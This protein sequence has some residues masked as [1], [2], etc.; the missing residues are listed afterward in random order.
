MG[1]GGENFCE[2]GVMIGD[3]ENPSKRAGEFDSAARDPVRS[4]QFIT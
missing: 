2:R 4:P 3:G 1:A